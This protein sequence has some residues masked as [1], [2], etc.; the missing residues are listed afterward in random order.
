MIR[1]EEVYKIGKIGKPHG[2]KGELTL[3]FDDDVFDRVAADYLVLLIDGILVP[4]Y[5]EEWRFKS[6]ET[7]LVKFE[8][9]DTKEEA[10]EIV[11]SEVYFPKH[12]SDRGDDELTWDELKGF[13]LADDNM[14]G[15]IVGK[16]V[17]I[18]EST[19]NVLLEVETAA[20]DVALIPASEDIIVD[21]DAGK[22]L[23]RAKLPEGL[24]DINDNN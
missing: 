9:I 15:T 17:G 3:F 4:F 1:Q 21:V 20:G 10:S 13:S 8:D 16:V 18:D 11:G 2:V 5:M 23:L 22:K 24:I 6:G 14:G 19:I 12:L 7:A